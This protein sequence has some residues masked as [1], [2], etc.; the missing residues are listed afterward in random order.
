[1]ADQTITKQSKV[2]DTP[3]A[4]SYAAATQLTGKF[5]NSGAGI[6]TLEINNTSTD[7]TSTCTVAS[8]TASD[9]GQTND[10]TANIEPAT[11]KTFGPFSQRRFNDGDDF[12]NYTLDT[13]TDQEVG[14]VEV[15]IV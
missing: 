12:V 2:L 8:P 13:T 15:P 7:T 3:S 11:V 4:T 9:Q 6:R 1:M 10:I 5:D 14:V